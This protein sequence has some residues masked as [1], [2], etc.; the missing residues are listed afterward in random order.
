MAVSGGY[1]GS[2]PKG[3]PITGNLDPAESILFHAGTARD[4]EGRLVTS[5]GRV[6]AATSYGD[7]IADA[8][9]KSY[10]VLDDVHFDGKYLRRDIGRDLMNL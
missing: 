7:C 10:A 4:A 6:I 2:Y 3:L 9:A 5:G 1:P 8:L